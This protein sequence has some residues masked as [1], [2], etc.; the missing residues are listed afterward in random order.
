MSQRIDLSLPL[1]GV[2]LALELAP[3]LQHSLLGKTRTINKNKKEVCRMKLFC[4]SGID[5]KDLAVSIK[6][7]T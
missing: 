7:Q 6:R 2:G 1:L 5:F 3:G 4:W